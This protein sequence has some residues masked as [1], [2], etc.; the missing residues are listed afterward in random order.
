[1]YLQEKFSHPPTSLLF[2][3]IIAYV[4]KIWGILF[5]LINSSKVFTPNTTVIKVFLGFHLC[6]AQPR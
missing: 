6:E 5:P 4:M 1:M 3:K 2:G